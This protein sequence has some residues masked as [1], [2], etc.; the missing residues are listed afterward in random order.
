VRSPNEGKRVTK[1]KYTA[2]PE[3]AEAELARLAAD[4][5][6]AFIAHRTGEVPAGEISVIVAVAA[7]HRDEA[8][9]SCRRLIEALKKDAPIWKQEFN[10]DGRRWVSNAQPEG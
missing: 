1:I 3:M 2:H 6:H 10:D 7:P 5:P 8:F 4:V 9:A